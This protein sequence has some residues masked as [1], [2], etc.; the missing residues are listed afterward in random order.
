[1]RERWAI[2]ICVLAVLAAVACALMFAVLHNPPGSVTAR[3][4]TPAPAS[5]AAEEALPPP[6]ENLPP[7]TEDLPPP[8]APSPA[9]DAPP[10]MVETES[11]AAARGRAIYEANR[12]NACHSIDDAGNPRAP[13]DGVGSR[14]TGPEL[15][16]WI[17]GSGAAAEHLSSGVIRRKQRYRDLPAGE[18][19]DLV[20]YLSALRD[21]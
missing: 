21:E 10:V 17:T 20:E 15:Q 13:L 9:A 4:G 14:R 12:C 18:M 1:M 6:K 3:S 19:A 2:A 8:A 16:E 11:E 7:P 5:P